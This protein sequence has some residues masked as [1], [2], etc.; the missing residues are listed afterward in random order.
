MKTDDEAEKFTSRVG[1]L[2]YVAPLLQNREIFLLNFAND[3]RRFEG[4]LDRLQATS[5]R[6][7]RERDKSGASLVGLLLPL[8]ILI[9]HCLLGFQQILSYQSFLAW[10]VFRPGLEAF[11]V[12]GK[13]VDDPANAKIWK[14]REVNPKLYRKTFSGKALASTS[15]PRSSDFRNAL[16]RLNDQFVHPNP[17]FAYRETSLRAATTE[18]LVA[19][20]RFFDTQ[21]EIHEAHLLSYLHLTELIVENLANL[22]TEILGPQE[23]KPSMPGSS[24][25]EQEEGERAESLAGRDST[26]KKIMEEL[27][28]WQ[29]SEK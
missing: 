28:L 18:T 24:A 6:I 10:L 15:I 27:G 13:W 11:L 8:Q 1:C 29:F 2:G 9:R 14:E 7:A 19:E 4:L 3:F 25:F 20:I 5:L 26:A 17:N 22:F 16:N 23:N 12:M 21:P